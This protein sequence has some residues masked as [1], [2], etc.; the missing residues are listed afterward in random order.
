VI[1]CLVLFLKTSLW[2][3]GSVVSSIWMM[4][5]TPLMFSMARFHWRT[6]QTGIKTLRQNDCYNAIKSI[7]IGFNWLNGISFDFVSWSVPEYSLESKQLIIF[8]DQQ[9][10]SRE[11]YNIVCDIAWMFRVCVNIRCRNSSH[12]VWWWHS[13]IDCLLAMHF[14]LLI[15]NTIENILN[16]HFSLNYTKL[17]QVPQL[18]AEPKPRWKNLLC[19]TL[20]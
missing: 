15:A 7:L 16:R 1:Y 4:I 18:I 8:F 20:Y 5:Q 17:N 6:N 3:W 11:T 2:W 14:L 10:I 13:C 9:V 12:P 19:I